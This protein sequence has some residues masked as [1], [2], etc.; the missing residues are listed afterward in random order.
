[1]TAI[2][3]ECL[4]IHVIEKGAGRATGIMK[5]LGPRVVGEI[6]VVT[7]TETIGG[8]R[9]PATADAASAKSSLIPML[10]AVVLIVEVERLPSWTVR[11]PAPIK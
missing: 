8:D 2:T 1:M 11:E 5:D 6:A 4:G 10:A 7:V 9:I 3:V